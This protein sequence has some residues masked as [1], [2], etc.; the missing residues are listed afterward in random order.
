MKMK[1]I[2][3]KLFLLS[4]VLLSYGLKAQERP[5]VILILADDMGLADFS[6][7]NGGLNRTP[8]LDRLR[9]EGVWFE[10][11]YSGSA[12]C[13]PARASLLT[14]KYP[15][16]TGVVS[17]TMKTEP[18]VT[19]LKTSEVTMADIFKAN[20]Y[21]TAL[22][23]KWHL[24]ILP[25]FHPMRRGFDHSVDFLGFNLKTYYDFK[26]DENGTFKQYTGHYL[27]DV[28]TDHALDYIET[29]KARPFFLHLAYSAPHRPLG[30]PEVLIDH[31][32]KKG[33]DEKTAKVYAMLEAMDKGIGRVLHKLEDLGI[34]QNT[35]V[36]FASDNGQDPGVG[37]RFNLDMKGHKYLVYEG[38]IHIPLLFHWPGHLEAGT[39]LDIAHFTDILPTLAE[40]CHLEVQ[41]KVSRDM[42][43]AS[44]V[45]SLQGK[46]NDGLPDARFWQWNRHEPYYSHNAAVRKEHWKLVRPV[47][48][49][50]M[51]YSSIIDAPSQLAPQLFNMDSDVPE[52]TD[53]SEQY[54][55][56]VT[57]LM[58]LLE[59]WG[60]SVEKDRL[61][62]VDFVDGQLK[63]KL[64]E[65][66]T[67]PKK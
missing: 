20:G 65:K 17:L 46:A 52:S 21:Q 45:N 55:Q 50:L 57:E 6:S 24:G 18:E 15:H 41:P 10:Q 53:L 42:D 63:K 47:A 4:F 39:T 66:T 12:V 22:V 67:E 29:N 23:G 26:L 51:E 61:K 37:T 5:N 11:A 44:L 56:K 58:D 60:K 14:G 33:F 7:T 28:L 9:A 35:L 31:Y 34:D 3:N 32:L 40:L 25:P 62:D 16:R 43:G 30:G 13:A 19:S 49:S 36:I 54:P 27:D 1:A 8:V 48:D 38:G 64:Q 59:Q 2:L